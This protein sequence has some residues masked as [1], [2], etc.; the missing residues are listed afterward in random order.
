M[1]GHAM[2]VFY[3]G[4]WKPSKEDFFK[5]DASGE[6]VF[7][8]PGYSHTKTLFGEKTSGGT[9]IPY[10]TGEYIL[11]LISKIESGGLPK[12]K[13]YTADIS[14]RDSM[15][16]TSYE[17]LESAI[18]QME[19]IRKTGKIIYADYQTIVNIWEFEF[20]SEPN[21]VSFESFS[22]YPLILSET[23]N[24]CSGQISGNLP[25]SQGSC[26]DSIC[27]GP[28]NSVNCAVD[29]G[30]QNSAVNSTVQGSCGDGICQDPER[31][32]NVCPEDCS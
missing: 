12:N 28:E 23:E 10:D 16:E 20:N 25:N 19:E 30:N 2:D 14:V 4:V 27:E 26:G 9:I 3:S 18:L 11:E 22:A 32:N 24:K 31:Q 29:C 1:Q 5:H 13:M 7:V 15:M 17:E 8:G 21:M 6:F